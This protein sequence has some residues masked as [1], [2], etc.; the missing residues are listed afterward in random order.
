MQTLWMTGVLDSYFAK[1]SSSEVAATEDGFEAFESIAFAREFSEKF[2]TFSS[3]NF[4]STQTA[5]AFLLEPEIRAS[6]LLEIDRLREKL[7]RREVVQ[8]AKLVSMVQWPNE[9]DRFQADVSVELEEGVGSTMVRSQFV[10]QLEFRISRT[11]RTTQNPWGFL[12]SGLKYNLKSE[13]NGSGVSAGPVNSLGKNE[14]KELASPVLSLRP[15]TALLVRFPCSIE[16]VELPKGTP[17]RVKLTTLDISELQMKSTV[18]LDGEQKLRAVCRDHVFNLRLQP[19]TPMD[20]LAGPSADPSVT[21]SVEP[22]TV[23]RLLTMGDAVKLSSEV[24]T[25]KNARPARSRSDRRIEKSI[26]DQLGFV[27]EE[28]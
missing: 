11:E 13:L 22:I 19:H 25:A 6:R 26:E 28:E 2:L 12:V 27:V 14:G 15:G 23:L 4:K 17:V 16:N 18:A 5:V 7:E 9:A 24:S 10:T 1:R 20:S 21:A 3:Y 8:K